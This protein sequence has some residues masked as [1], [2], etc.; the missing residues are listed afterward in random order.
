[1]SHIEEVNIVHAGANYGWFQRE[2]FY[3]N[4]V[5]KPGGVMNEVYSLPVD[6]LTGQTGDGFTYPVAIYDHDEGIAIT[7]G[8][9]Y[10]GS[11]P[12]LQGKFVF[13]DIQ[14]GRLF[15]ADVAEMKAADDG[16]PGTVAAVEEIQLFVRN[17]AGDARDVELWE[18]IETTL[19]QSVT[20]ADLHLSESLDGEIFV[21]SRQDGTIRMLVG[22]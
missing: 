10:R 7:A 11:I 6:I 5:D 14:R 4:G 19:G 13:G 2:G 17:E 8:Y 16:I 9:A 1:M 15:A 21:T 18:L 12:A 3:D 20:R 22:E